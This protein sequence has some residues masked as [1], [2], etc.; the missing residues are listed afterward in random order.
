MPRK[1]AV[2]PT[3]SRR[4]EK[5]RRVCFTPLAKPRDDGIGFGVQHDDAR[6]WLTHRLFPLVM[7]E[8]NLLC[9][10]LIIT[11]AGVEQ[12]T[13]PCSRGMLNDEHFPQRGN[14]VSKNGFR[15]RKP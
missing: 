12:F 13:R 4:R 7:R 14:G 3:L 15:T 11:H 5:E 9:A 6:A 8:N 2:V 10:T 1:K